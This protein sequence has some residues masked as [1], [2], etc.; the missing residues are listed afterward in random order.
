M[1]TA[2]NHVICIRPDGAIEALYSEHVA[3]Q[4]LGEM[5]VTR[6][7]HVEFDEAEQVWY[8][9]DA[10]TGTRI[11]QDASRGR[12]LGFETDY[13]ALRLTQGFQPFALS[14]SV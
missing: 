7:S 8:V 10:A 12:C 14:P 5:T 6:A 4:D 1:S 9:Q 13:F 3:L 11:F 2:T